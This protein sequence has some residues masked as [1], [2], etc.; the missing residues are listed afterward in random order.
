MFQQWLYNCSHVAITVMEAQGCQEIVT[1]AKKRWF[2]D[3]NFWSNN[4]WRPGPKEASILGGKAPGAKWCWVGVNTGGIT[5]GGSKVGLNLKSEL[6][7]WVDLTSDIWGTEV[8][9]TK[10]SGP[11]GHSQWRKSTKVSL[12]EGDKGQR[13]EEVSDVSVQHDRRHSRT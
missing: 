11:K 13:A 4:Y 6:A 12:S 9:K 7:S 1:N 5:W 2:L 10:K 3:Q 8:P